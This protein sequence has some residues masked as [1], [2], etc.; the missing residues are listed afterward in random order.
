MS[1]RV[2]GGKNMG[3]EVG[4]NSSS[5]SFMAFSKL[6]NLPALASLLQ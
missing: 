4:V 3:H 2:A 6:F 1:G 5:S